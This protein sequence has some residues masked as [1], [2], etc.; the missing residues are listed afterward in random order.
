V[1]WIEIK[2][3]CFNIYM[4]HSTLHLQ[5]NTTVLVQW[6]LKEQVSQMKDCATF[7][8]LEEITELTFILR[9]STIISCQVVQ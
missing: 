1:K 6:T 7:S 8:S 3:S 5:G 2:N 4:F 9:K